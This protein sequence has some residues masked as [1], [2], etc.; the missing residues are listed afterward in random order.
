[1]CKT[2]E[3]LDLDGIDTV[4]VD[5]ET[6]DP[7]L[8]YGQNYGYRSGLNK[9]MVNHLNNKVKKILSQIT[10][11]QDDIVVDIGSNDCTLLRAYP[12][13]L[14]LVGFDPTGTKFK[15]FYPDHITLIADFFNSRTFKK[16]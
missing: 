13:K 8:M 12:K 14:N 4:A 3:D 9:S 16:I 11:N 10:L 1:M 5:L 15:K 6:Y 7:N 2:P